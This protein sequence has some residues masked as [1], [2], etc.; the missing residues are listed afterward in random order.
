VKW[1]SLYNYLKKPQDQGRM[2]KAY[3]GM[4][5]VVEEQAW[6]GEWYTR[7][8]DAKG[9]PVG[10]KVCEKGKIFIESQGWCVLG[11]AGSRQWPGPPGLGERSQTS[12]YLQRGYPSAAGLQHLSPGIG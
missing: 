10:S 12:L 7:A 5:K 4:L 8:Y 1:S 2:Q 11:G 6:D 9:K 3:D